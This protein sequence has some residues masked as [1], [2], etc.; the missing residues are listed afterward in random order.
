MDNICIWTGWG[1]K[2]VGTTVT[3]KPAA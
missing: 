3:Y 1:E 2:P